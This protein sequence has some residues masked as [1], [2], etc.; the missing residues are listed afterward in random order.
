MM[1]VGCG[2]LSSSNSRPCVPREVGGGGDRQHPVTGPSAATLVPRVVGV[3]HSGRLC[4]PL[5]SEI[6]AVACTYLCSL[7]K[8][9]TAT[10]ESACA[11]KEVLMAIL[12]MLPNNDALL[13]CQSQVSC[14]QFGCST[15]FPCPLRLFLHRQPSSSP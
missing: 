12:P 5:E 9:Y 4:P 2:T 1:V 15:P 14:T 7:R 6:S 11:E 13:L 8:R 10:Q 3:A